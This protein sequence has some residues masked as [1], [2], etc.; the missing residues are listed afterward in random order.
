MNSNDAGI[1]SGTLLGNLR[2]KKF[3]ILNIH[4]CPIIYIEEFKNIRARLNA[5]DSFPTLMPTSWPV[6]WINTIRSKPTL[7]RAGSMRLVTDAAAGC[8]M[9]RFCWCCVLVEYCC[10]CCGGVGIDCVVVCL[11]VDEEAT[12]GRELLVALPESTAFSAWVCDRVLR[13]TMFSLSDK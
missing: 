9:L 6:T 5:E 13:I 12:P 2:I 4:P 10:C 3:A 7:S 8:C 11:I 1:F